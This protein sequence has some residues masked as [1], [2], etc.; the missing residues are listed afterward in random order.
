MHI[1]NLAA[2][3]SGGSKRASSVLKLAAGADPTTE[4]AHMASG[5]SRT[6][7]DSG[8]GRS[9]ETGV[10]GFSDA[11]LRAIATVVRGVLAEVHPTARAEEEDR[12]AP[13]GPSSEPPD[14]ERC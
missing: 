14:G 4:T 3:L 2:W 7:E 1:S 10:A 11:Q 13:Q 12:S 9:E 5:D 6:P 8:L